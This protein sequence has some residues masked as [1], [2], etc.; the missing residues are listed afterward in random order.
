DLT[1]AGKSM[2]RDDALR[3][4]LNERRHFRDEK[5]YADALAEHAGGEERTLTVTND[6]DI[7]DAAR[8]AQRGLGDRH[9]CI[10]IEALLFRIDAAQH[11]LLAVEVLHVG[12]ADIVAWIIGL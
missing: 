3:V 6:W 1:D 10:R 5:Q 2:L 7:D 11:E 12:V 8:F 4:I 9:D